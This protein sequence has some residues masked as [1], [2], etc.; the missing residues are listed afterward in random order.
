[1]SWIALNARRPNHEL[2]HQDHN[3]ENGRVH[4]VLIVGSYA[5]LLPP[6]RIRCNQYM[7]ALRLLHAPPSQLALCDTPNESQQTK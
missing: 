3:S 2:D 4:C 6:V 5:L 7:Q 1:M